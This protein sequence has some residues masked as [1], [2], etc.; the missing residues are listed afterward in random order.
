MPKCLLEVSRKERRRAVVA[1]NACG[2]WHLRK[3]IHWPHKGA[4]AA[5]KDLASCQGGSAGQSLQSFGGSTRLAGF[6]LGLRRWAGAVRHRRQVAVHGLQLQ[7]MASSAP[8]LRAMPSP[9]KHAPGANHVAAW[10]TIRPCSPAL[11]KYR[12]LSPFANTP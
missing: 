5:P 3:R 4:G 10:R 1:P 6:V 12:Y 7:R 11:V 2:S 8:G 9:L